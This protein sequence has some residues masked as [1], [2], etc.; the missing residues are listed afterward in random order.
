MTQAEVCKHVFQNLS[1]LH[2]RERLDN[3]WKPSKF[4]RLL[5]FNLKIIETYLNNE[6]WL[7]CTYQATA[8]FSDKNRL[9]NHLL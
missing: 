2:G 4:L 1:N 8:C 6:F 5:L 3:G 7:Y 9:Q